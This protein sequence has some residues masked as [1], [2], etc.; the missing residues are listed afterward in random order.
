MSDNYDKK[1]LQ[2]DQ[3]ESVFTSG[4][5]VIAVA[6]LLAGGIVYTIVNTIIGA[7]Q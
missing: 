5:G 2:R 6:I 7:V 1:K 4:I 3:A